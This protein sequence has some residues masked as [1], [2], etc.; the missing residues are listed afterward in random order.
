MWKMVPSGILVPFLQLA[1]STPPQQVTGK[2]HNSPA[3]S[4]L[5]HPPIQLWDPS[6]FS[7]SRP[8]SWAIMLA[9]DLLLLHRIQAV[10]SC[11]IIITTDGSRMNALLH[12]FAALLHQAILETSEKR[13]HIGLGQQ[14]LTNTNPLGAINSAPF[15]SSSLAG[16]DCQGCLLRADSHTQRVHR[17]TNRH[18]FDGDCVS[19]I[20]IYNENAERDQM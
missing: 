10:C 6:W 18:E 19:T 3:S 13:D 15:Y 5:Q 9:S 14:E 2:Q 4:P 1:P 8:E 20:T 7:S 11:R 16:V 12:R 17:S